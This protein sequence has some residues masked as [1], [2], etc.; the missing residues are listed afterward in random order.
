MLWYLLVAVVFLLHEKKSSP[1]R[2]VTKDFN[3]QVVDTDM[4][5]DMSA[6]QYAMD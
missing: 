6:E 2:V 3:S 5:P 4:I 1:M